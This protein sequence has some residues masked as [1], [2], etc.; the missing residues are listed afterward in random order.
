MDEARSYV[1]AVAE[2]EPRFALF[3]CAD[4]EE[5][6]AG[7]LPPFYVKLSTCPHCGSGPAQLVELLE[8][9]SLRH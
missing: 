6:F 7:L 2:S 3:R 5:K 1:R 9:D 8:R 4:C